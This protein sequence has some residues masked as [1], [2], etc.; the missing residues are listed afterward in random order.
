MTWWGRLSKHQWALWVVISA[1][2][3]DGILLAASLRER[4]E[5]LANAEQRLRIATAFVLSE[6][7]ELFSTVDRTL[8]G[9]NEVLAMRGERQ[10]AP[11]RALHQLLLRRHVMTPA[12][13]WLALLRSDG[14][15]A[16]YSLAFPAPRLDLRQRPYFVAP[17]AA[18]TAL[19]I[20]RV[21]APGFD[22]QS[23]IP[24][25][26]RAI[27]GT[28]SPG[29]V[30]AG[31][32]PAALADSIERTA[33]WP[34]FVVRLYLTDGHVLA[35]SKAEASCSG[36]DFSATPLFA[37]HLAQAAS[38]VGEALRL[39]A[40]EAGVAAYAR[41]ERFPLVVSAESPRAIALAPWYQT[42]PHYLLVAVGS[43]L[44][45]IMLAFV[46]AK[47]VGRQRDAM[48]AL[49]EAKARL[50]QRVA[51]RTR[52]L[53]ISEARARAFMNTAMDA[54]IV[55][56]ETSRILEF[57]PIAERMFGFA[58]DEVLGGDVG[59]LM[60]GAT[61]RAHRAEVA[62]STVVSA[63]RPMGRG[64]EVIARRK[65]GEHFPVEVTVGTS[66]DEAGRKMHVGIV[67]DITERKAAERELQRLATTDGLTG[68]L[69]RRAFIERAEEDF[70]LARRHARSLAVLAI[71]ADFFKR[72]NDTYGHHV[73]DDVLRALTSVV[74]DCLRDTDLFGRLGGEEFGV[75][76]PE[77]DQRGASELGQRI[78][79]AARA[80]GVKREG[81]EV[82]T[83]TI[84]IG[85]AILDRQ[86]RG[87]EDLLRRADERLYAAKQN[88]RDR[89]ES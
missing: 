36:T 50:E 16:E 69:N 11:D 72:I 39:T 23:F 18:P 65:S 63:V 45:L 41:S 40:D 12:L 85:V 77:T 70:L 71:D 4:R 31:V 57:N 46:A 75:V 44:A 56:D 3:I 66:S 29:V 37:L 35:C 24:T 38:A 8:T 30:V 5:A 51:E 81:G 67:R 22:G 10:R 84:S 15:L 82:V 28:R 52:A 21:Q 88:G 1:L 60:P 74:S 9:V 59:R 48:A 43:N 2:T 14:T 27:D 7:D 13:R 25:S 53:S 17:L 49:A 32:D 80:S 76:L 42:L 6:A 26:R 73:G 86:D 33:P 19:Y 79:A 62:N 20:G 61:A 87:I 64:R 78:L 34:G 68:V 89:L 54:I 55:I 83:F 58:A 47:A